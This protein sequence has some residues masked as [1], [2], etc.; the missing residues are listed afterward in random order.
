MQNQE[1]DWWSH[2]FQICKIIFRHYGRLW[3]YLAIGTRKLKQK[4][5]KMRQWLTPGKGD[6]FVQEKRWNFAM[7]FGSAVYNVCIVIKMQTLNLDNPQVVIKLSL[8]MGWGLWVYLESGEAG[9]QVYVRQVLNPN[10]P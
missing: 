5:K 2:S 3:K 7:L 6:V 9:Q 4:K 1:S 10:L 8:K